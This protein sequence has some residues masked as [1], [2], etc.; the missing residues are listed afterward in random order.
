MV[1]HHCITR[2]GHSSSQ[3][4]PRYFRHYTWFTTTTYQT[5]HRRVHKEDPKIVPPNDEISHVAIITRSIRWRGTK[6]KDWF[7]HDNGEDRSLSEG[8]E[9]KGWNCRR[10]PLSSY[11][12]HYED[13]RRLVNCLYNTSF[14]VF[15][16]QPGTPRR[17][18]AF[19]GWNEPENESGLEV[20]LLAV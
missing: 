2:L 15:C 5:T 8:R 14:C 7:R 6:K 3:S 12:E 11:F 13:G 18:M 17:V 1:S 19:I 9:D 16:G 10:K 20:G 4:F